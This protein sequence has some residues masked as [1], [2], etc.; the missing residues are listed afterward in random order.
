MSH[1]FCWFWPSILSQEALNIR[2]ATDSGYFRQMENRFT[3]VL[4]TRISLLEKSRSGRDNRA[5]EELLGYYEPFITKILLRMGFRAADADDARQ[6]VALNLWKGLHSY[7]AEANGARFRNWFST[8]IRN[9]AIDWIRSQRR[10][11]GTAP[12]NPGDL[13]QLG[14]ERP[15]ID[16]LIEQE[17]QQHVVDLAMQ[18]LRQ[19]FSG[20]AFEVFALTL[21]GESVDAIA[22]ELDLRKESVYVLRTRVKTRLRH[23]IRRIRIELEGG[24]HD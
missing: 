22:E 19:V 6:Q 16:L 3:D 10:H 21:A 1:G 23:E 14:P 7:Q 12:F 9:T 17:W 15:G 4:P 8:L 20:K 11:G 24:G 2:K 18:N 13:D 5:W